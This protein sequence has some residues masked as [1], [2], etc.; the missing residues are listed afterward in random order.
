MSDTDRRATPSPADAGAAAPSRPHR[1]GPTASARALGDGAASHGGPQEAPPRLA[2]RPQPQP[3]PTP[4]A[5]RPTAAADDDA[6]DDRSPSC[7]TRP[8]RGPTATIA[9]ARRARPLVPQAA[10]RRHAGPRRAAGAAGARADADAT[11]TA[12]ER[13]RR[14]RRRRRGGRGRRRRGGGTAAAAG[15]RRRPVEARRATT[16]RSSSTTRRSSAGAGRERKGRPV[17]RYLMCVHVAARGATQIAVLEGR[18]LIEHYVSQPADD[19]TPDPRQHLPRPGAERAARH[20]GRVRRHRHAEERAC[21]T[22]ATCSTTRRTSTRR[23][24]NAR[25]EQMLQGRPDD[26]LPGH[27]EPDRRQGRAAH[28]GGV[29]ARAASSC[30]SRTATTYGISKRLPDDERKRLRAILDR[31]QPDGA[32]R[33]SCAPRPR[34][35]PPRSSSATSRRLVAAVG[36]DRRAR[37]SGRRRRRCSTRS[38]TW[39]SGSS[40]RSSTRSTA[41][42][43]STTPRSTRRCATTSRRSRPSSP[44][45]SSTTTR[46]TRRCRSS[47]GSTSTSSCTRRS[48]ARCG[49]RRAARSIIERT[50]ALTVIDVNT[51]KNVG[52]S[53]LEETVFRNNLEAAE[54]IA[55]QLRLR[56]IG[57]I[58]VID[59]ID[60]EIREN[61]DDG[62]RASSATRSPATRP[63]PR[64]S[65]SPS[66]AWSR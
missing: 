41:A 47:S 46:T 1:R 33:S 60:M 40:A 14:R 23:A 21:S 44:T 29:P 22:A 9:E 52:T 36:A 56:D 66:S 12:A 43:S 31:V 30:W 58:I 59:F 64:C 57:G 28:A 6:D 10:D 24:R 39:R 8:D 27:E 54:E 51:G 26:R 53:N 18:A 55:R 20:G 17:G 50:E 37:P 63:A 45:G 4:D 15:S 62:D 42:S 34:A 25:I 13:R 19:A 2:R 38:P 11:A 65:T 61:R 5:A 32:R 48:T 49:C 16:R 35:P 7:P 3:S